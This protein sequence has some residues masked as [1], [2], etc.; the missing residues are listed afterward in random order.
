[1]PRPAGDSL[2]RRAGRSA[3]AYGPGLLFRGAWAEGIRRPAKS[4]R[5]RRDLCADRNGDAQAVISR[6]VPKRE[7]EEAGVFRKLCRINLFPID[8]IFLVLL[9]NSPAIAPKYYS[10]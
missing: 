8:P 10:S 1:V 4:D 6:S 3:Y 9:V 5:L 2:L 7:S